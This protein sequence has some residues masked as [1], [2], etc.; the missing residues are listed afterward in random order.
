[1]LRLQSFFLSLAVFAASAAW[2]D[3]LMLPSGFD[4]PKDFLKNRMTHVTVDIKGVI[5]ETVVYQEFVNESSRPVDA[6]YS[7]P[8]PPD[9][10]ATRFNYWLGDQ[11]FRA[12]LRVKEQAVNPGTGE[13]GVV[14]EVNKYMGRNGLRI[15]L[16]NIP[17]GGIQR[18]RLTYIS[19]C[20]YY[21]GRTTYT[22]PFDTEDFIPYPIEHVQFDFNVTSNSTITGYDIP[23]HSNYRILSESSSGVALELAAPKTY[24]NQNITFFYETEQSEI[25]VDFYSVALDTADGHFALVVRPESN[26]PPER[27]LAKRVLFLLSNSTG[28]FGYKLSESISAISQSLDRLPKTDFFNIVLFSGVVGRWQ[29]QPVPANEANIQAAKAFLATV[30]NASGSRMQ[31][32]IAEC[33]RQITDADFSNAILVFADGRSPL[34]PRQIETLNVYQAGIFPIGIG[35][36]LDRARLEMTAALNY[37]FVTYLNED[38]NLSERMVQVFSQISAPVLSGVRM[39]Y[40]RADLSQILPEKTPTTYAGSNFF[41]VGRYRNPGLSGLSIAGMA[42]N[43]ITSFDFQL[44]FASQTTENKFVESLWAKE[45]IDALER[46]IEVY[47]ET[48]A[49]K[50]EVIKLSLAYLIRSRYTAYVADY[51]TEEPATSVERVEAHDSVVPST[52]FLAG[53]YPNPFNPTTKIKFYIKAGAENSTK[54]LR[55]Y[56]S[57]GQLVAVIDISHLRSGWHEIEFNGRDMFGNALPS[58]VYYVQLQIRNQATSVIRMSLLK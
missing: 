41:T 3:G 16:K 15:K 11:L 34:D 58:G 18:V 37:G 5:A 46:E 8:L 7:F 14:A 54:L 12:V 29:S 35:N 22:Y 1:M 56:N 53:N 26:A 20:D 44:D 55:I 24:A 6:V 19:V 23:G 52:S 25:G 17:A 2:A 27:V 21:Q 30:T 4:Y 49:L 47:G 51:E 28:M 33:L 38:D 40:G 45:K 48:P 31:D 39:E 43:G 42:A 9:A 10:R 36:S 57:L 32:G 50:Q 13:G